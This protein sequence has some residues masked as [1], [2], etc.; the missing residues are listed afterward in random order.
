MCVIYIS[1][2]NKNNYRIYVTGEEIKL[3]RNS[4]KGM[5]ILYIGKN[6]VIKNGESVRLDVGAIK[7]EGGTRICFYVNGGRVIDCLDM[8]KGIS[9]GSLTLSDDNQKGMSVQ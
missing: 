3:V 6:N 9:G 5:Q 8:Y 4:E 2:R 7:A 1:W